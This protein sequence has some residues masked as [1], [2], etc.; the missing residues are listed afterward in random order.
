MI[1]ETS[2]QLK[3]RARGTLLGHYGLPIGA[4]VL[5]TAAI[6][7]LEGLISLVV[8]KNTTGILISYLTML[9]AAIF[10]TLLQTGYEY[11]LLNMARG[12]QAQL[13]DLIYPFQTMPDHVILLA[14]RLFL[15][16]L[17]CMLPFFG[18]IVIFALF[19]HFLVSR[20]IMV[21]LLLVSLFLILKLTLDYSQIFLLY[22][23]NPYLSC[24]EIMQQSKELM[25]GNRIRYFYLLISFFGISLLGVVSL[26]IGFLWIVPYMSMT[27]V[28]FYRD[29]IHEHSSDGNQEF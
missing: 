25:K 4:S 6:M 1:K 19:Y 14:V 11:L 13:S 17:A 16:T 21:L 12:K 28:E 8:P 20:I 3:A 27:E 15:L 2:N 23:D 24:K 5:T 7:A 10:S 22:L 29:L 9:I 26:G 18:G